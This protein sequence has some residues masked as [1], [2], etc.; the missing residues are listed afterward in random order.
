MKVRIRNADIAYDDHGIGYPI[1]FLHAFPLNRSMWEGQVEALLAEQR[2]RLVALDWRGFGESEVPGSE[3]MTMESLADDVAGLMDA[4][5]M[6]EAILCGLSMGGYAAFAFL[7]KYPQR[8]KGLILADTRPG[9]DSEE[10]K[11]NRERVAEL[12]LTEGTDAI[13]NLQIPN[14]LASTTRRESPEVEARIRRLIAA[15]SPMGIAAASRGMALRHDATDLLETITCPTLVIV[16]SEDRLTT[17]QIAREYA[18]RI[19]GARLTVIEHSGHLSNLEQPNAFQKTL[20]SFL[21]E[22]F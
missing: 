7:R 11:A 18:E 8:V 12:A 22:A 5:G 4:L 16:G 9:V 20:S 15:A 14:L 19:P 10:G 1:L 13:A 21:R 6:Q 3:I 2:F 17:P